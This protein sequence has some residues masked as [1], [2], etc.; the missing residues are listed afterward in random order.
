MAQRLIQNI[1]GG[2]HRHEIERVSRSFTSNMYPETVEAD[3]ST[4]NKVLLGIKGTS[5]ALHMQEGPCR[6]LYRASRGN[7]GNPVLFG[8]WGSSVYVIR[9]TSN[10]FVKRRSA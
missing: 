5:L 2:I 7:D 6:G 1:V 4:T 3:Q 9:E 8:C 10:G